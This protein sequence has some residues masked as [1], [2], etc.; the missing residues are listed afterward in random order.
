MYAQ[1]SY[2]NKAQLKTYLTKDINYD[3]DVLK[4]KAIDLF[5]NLIKK[6]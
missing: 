4:K 6:Q 3:F 1:N 2:I 5:L